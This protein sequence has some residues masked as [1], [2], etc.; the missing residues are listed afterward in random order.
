M[1]EATPEKDGPNVEETT[2]RPGRSVGVGGVSSWWW[3]C[4]GR[5]GGFGGL[6]TACCCC[7]CCLLCC[8]LLLLLLLLSEVWKF[9]L[10]SCWNGAAPLLCC[11]AGERGFRLR[12]TEGTERPLGKLSRSFWSRSASRRGLLLL[13]LVLPPL[14]L[15][16]VL[17]DCLGIF[18][19]E[20]G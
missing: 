17:V 12:L 5:L 10:L 6:L 15:L 8:S 19:F 16:L 11:G 1:V 20:D 18:V 13:L 3:C 2:D 14:L 7:C 4:W 9:L